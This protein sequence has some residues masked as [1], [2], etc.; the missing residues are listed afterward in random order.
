MVREGWS[1]YFVKYG[2]SRLYHRQFVEAEAEAQAK[3]KGI[4]DPET[5]AGG[6]R[7]DYAALIPWWHLREHV[8]QDYRYAG[9]QAGVLSV[10]L[11]YDDIVEA[12]K[13]GNEMTVLCDLQ[14]GIDK[15]PSNGALIYAG[16]KFHKFNLWIPNRDSVNSQT[17]LRLIETRYAGFGRG[18]V[19]VSGQA[20]LYPPNPQ[21]KP[22]IVLSDLQQLADMP[23]GM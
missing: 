6:P 4:W 15:W 2:R 23:P 16:S 13:A 18:Y 10:R 1:P 12:A 5:N 20:S 7:R 22:Q 19:Y 8:V 11:N 21:G 3:G 9:S 14:G 17:I